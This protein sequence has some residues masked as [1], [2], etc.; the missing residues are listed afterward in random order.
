M[1]GHRSLTAEDLIA[2]GINLREDA[3]LDAAGEEAESDQ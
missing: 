3:E 1:I 2:L